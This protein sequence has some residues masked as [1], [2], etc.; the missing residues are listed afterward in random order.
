MKTPDIQRENMSIFGMITCK[1]VTGIGMD[2]L[3]DRPI[4]RIH[5]MKSTTL[6]CSERGENGGL[7]AW[8]QGKGGGGYIDSRNRV[9][10]PQFY[11][12]QGDKFRP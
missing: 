4:L 5:S 8:V 1:T 2:F 10:V 12:A 6:T 11:P 3:E 9:G 7:S